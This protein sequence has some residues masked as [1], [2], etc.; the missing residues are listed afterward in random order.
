MTAIDFNDLKVHKY[1]IVHKL[2]VGTTIL[3]IV[4]TLISIIPWT[5]SRPSYKYIEFEDTNNT[6]LNLQRCY[7]LC[8][9]RDNTEKGYSCDLNIEPVVCDKG[10]CIC[11]TE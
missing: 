10:S 11:K 6:A 5:T 7:S 8:I 9:I 2:S 3:I 1:E 4:C